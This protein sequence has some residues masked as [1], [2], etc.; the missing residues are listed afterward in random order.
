MMCRARPFRYQ[1]PAAPPVNLCIQ[2]C[3]GGITLSANTSYYI[4]TQETAGGDEWYD[5]DTT[6]QTTSV[7]GLVA[8]EYGLPYSSISGSSGHLYGPVDFQYGVIVSKPAITQQP[9]SQTVGAGSTATF[10]VTASGGGLSYQWSSAP[11]GSSTFTAI[12]GATASS[13]TTPATT[14][15]Q[16][17]TQYICMVSNNAGPPLRT[18][19]R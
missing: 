8:S 15:A 12:S 3:S 16:S 1:C 18:R 13:Y 9:Q 5:W 19:Q 2:I 7:A 17:G 4:L 11:S 6:A 14:L 10:S